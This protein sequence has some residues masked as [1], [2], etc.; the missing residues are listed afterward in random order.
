MRRKGTRLPS[1]PLTRSVTVATT[2][3]AGVAGFT[4][5]GFLPPFVVDAS[6]WRDFLTGP[7]VAGAFAVLAAAVA[8]S[9]A[10]R[11][12]REQRRASEREEWWHRAE[13]ALSR[14]LSDNVTERSAGIQAS[15]ALVQSATDSE[16]AI[17]RAVLDPF[18]GGENS[19][20]DGLDA[21]PPAAGGS[22]HDE[23]GE[24]DGADRA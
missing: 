16:A 15:S 1:R 14:A 23:R 18:F 21:A 10:E 2:A 20:A 19:T 12:A 3:A 24:D 5:R 4:V 17:V 13:W 6:F 7:P 8:Y 9:A 11:N 22:G